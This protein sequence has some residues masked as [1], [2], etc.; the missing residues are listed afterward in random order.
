MMFLGIDIPLLQHS[1]VVV[2]A[3]SVSFLLAEVQNYN[4]CSLLTRK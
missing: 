4:A 3:L 1:L 2:E